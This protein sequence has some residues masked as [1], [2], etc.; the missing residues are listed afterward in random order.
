MNRR[1]DVALLNRP[2][3]RRRLVLEKVCIADG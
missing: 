1:E 2:R 3:T